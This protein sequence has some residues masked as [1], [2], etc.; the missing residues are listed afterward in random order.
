MQLRFKLGS[1]IRLQDLI[2]FIFR[3]GI[4]YKVKK[5]TTWSKRER[6]DRWKFLSFWFSRM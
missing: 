4:Q 6:E 2:D 5:E 3:Y 1:D